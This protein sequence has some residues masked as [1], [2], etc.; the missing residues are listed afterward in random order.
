MNATQRVTLCMFLAKRRGHVLTFAVAGL[1]G[2]HIGT[3]LSMNEDRIR[4]QMPDREFVIRTDN[5]LT[6]GEYDPD[7]KRREVWSA[8]GQEDTN[9]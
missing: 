5:V 4:L 8:T 3:L 2:R 9:A 6:V 1:Q 7:I